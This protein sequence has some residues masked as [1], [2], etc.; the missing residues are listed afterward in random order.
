[1]LENWRKG[2]N[3]AAE[4]IGHKNLVEVEKGEL[5]KFKQLMKDKKKLNEIKFNY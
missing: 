2:N 5:D 4:S 1:M 3:R